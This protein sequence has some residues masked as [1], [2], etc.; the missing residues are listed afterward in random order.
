M[1]EDQLQQIKL[2]RSELVALENY[3]CE[4]GKIAFFCVPSV[5]HA[6]RQYGIF[7]GVQIVSLMMIRIFFAL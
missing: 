2:N 6:L 3:L 7:L 1:M 4:H 5:W